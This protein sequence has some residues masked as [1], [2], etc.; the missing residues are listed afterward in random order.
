MTEFNT[1]YLKIK[2]YPLS[3]KRIDKWIV[4]SISIL[5]PI[6]QE[7]PLT[8]LNINVS[9]TRIKNLI[10]NGNVLIDNNL[11]TDPSYILKDENEICIKFPKPI[12]PE[13]KP[14]K[15][16]LN[17][18]YEDKDLL[19][20]DK[21]S[22]LVVHP[23]PGN[24]SG[25]LVNGI[26][27][28]CNNSLSGIGGVKRPGIVHRLDKNTSGLMVVAKSEIAHIN[29]VKMFQNRDLDRRYNALVWGL[30][31]FIGNIDKPIGRS[32]VDRKKMSVTETGKRAITKWKFLRTFSNVISLIECKLE[33]GRTHQIR[34]HMA[35][36][37]HHL[38]GDKIYGKKVSI[39][40]NLSN[41][42]IYNLNACKLFQRQALH[43][44]KISFE[45][46]I[47]KKLM[48]FESNFPKDIENLI[49]SLI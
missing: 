19:V 10:Q 21:Q 42:Q 20:I 17:I 22:G 14:E 43:S 24:E 8:E 32:K 5:N 7:Q 37:G 3:Y 12:H 23:A 2:N 48:K 30:P 49:K 36:S 31:N 27:Y 15:I 6:N 26:I 38:I 25:T 9:R 45:H 47:T 46:P 40:K 1:I 13:P 16:P 33:T 18:I 28:Y 44:S 34:V 41:N 35:Y 11:I 39:N 4:E 29:L